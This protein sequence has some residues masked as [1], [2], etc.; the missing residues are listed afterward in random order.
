MAANVQG[1]AKAVWNKD[2]TG[3]GAPQI[4]LAKNNAAANT[5]QAFAK[6]RVA[7]S[8]YFAER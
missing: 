6:S 7:S 5:L 3:G 2:T 8:A 4:F 1:L